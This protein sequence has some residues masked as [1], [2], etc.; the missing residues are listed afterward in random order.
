MSHA[1]LMWDRQG[2]ATIATICL[3]ACCLVPVMALADEGEQDLNVA[4]ALQ[5]SGDLSKAKAML[6]AVADKYPKT[7]TSSLALCALSD[8]QLGLKQ[9]TEAIATLDRV[10]GDAFSPALVA[11][12]VG[13]KINIHANVIRNYEEAIKTGESFLASSDLAVMPDFPRAYFVN[14]MANCYAQ[15]GQYDKGIAICQK[16]GPDTPALL[17]VKGYYDRLLDMQLKAGRRQEALSTARLC[18]AICDFNQEEIEK[19][20][21]LVRKGFAGGGDISKAMQFVACQADPKAP[22]PLLAVALPPITDEQL[23][24][25]LAMYMTTGSNRIRAYLCAGKYREAMTEATLAVGSVR[26]DQMTGALQDVAR[27]F[28][29]HD[30]NLVRANQ[31]LTYAKTGTGSS[32]V[33]EFM[34]EVK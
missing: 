15:A 13:A 10:V 14:T 6:Q 5:K 21:D 8:A 30:L 23:Q 26:M 24:K 12:A 22:N 28:K 25:H 4:L 17:T 34:Q 29:A 20:G 27:V 9:P 33:D 7:Q 32:P 3:L 2:R 19:A 1:A 16:Y 31:F 11:R 18:Y